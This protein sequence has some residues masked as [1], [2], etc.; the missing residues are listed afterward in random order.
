MSGVGK[1]IINA[2]VD[3]EL[4]TGVFECTFVVKLKEYKKLY[5]QK[6]VQNF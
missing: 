1:G 5:F 3:V 4:A 6:D 2:G